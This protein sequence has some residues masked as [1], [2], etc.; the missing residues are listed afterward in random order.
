VGL[1]GVAFLLEPEAPLLSSPSPS[2]P[3]ETLTLAPAGPSPAQRKRE[4]AAIG[5]LRSFSLLR[6]PLLTPAPLPHPAQAQCNEREREGG[7]HLA[8]PRP[9]AHCDTVVSA[10]LSGWA[11]VR[12]CR[13]GSLLSGEDELRVHWAAEVHKVPFLFFPS[14]EVCSY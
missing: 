3:P 7:D 4:G 1:F 9:S 8:E 11:A 6:L 2:A 5:P 13:V 10:S 12:W 14:A